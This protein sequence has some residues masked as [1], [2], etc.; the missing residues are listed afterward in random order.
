VCVCSPDKDL[1]QV[2]RGTNVVQL[3]R[4]R[5]K[6]TTAA[7]FQET[8]GFAPASVPDFLGL[9]GDAADGIPGL[10]GFGEKTV[11]G[12]LGAH[13]HL[14]EL[15][16]NV[17]SWSASVRGGPRLRQTL[18]AGMDD[19]LLYRKL[20]TLRYDVPLTETADDLKYEG[21][22]DVAFL[23]ELGAGRIVERLAP[24]RRA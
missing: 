5:K 22:K 3:D 7:S 18:L 16:A 19:A 9:V 17:D 23:R 6:R 24:T 21:P 13:A 10:T 8:R 2:L 1:S 14:E 11:S 15:L 12:L 4:I 20:A